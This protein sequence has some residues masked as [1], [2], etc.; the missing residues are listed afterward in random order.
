[1]KANN[2]SAFNVIGSQS[3]RALIF[4]MAA[5]GS[6]SSALAADATS[7]ATSQVIEVIA[8]SAITPLNFGKFIP[9]V[10]AGSVTI[11]ND[12]TRTVTAVTAVNSVGFS[13]AQFSVTGGANATYA[14]T[15][16]GVAVLTGV[17]G[18]AGPTM[19]LTK[20]S[21][22]AADTTSG[23]VSVGTLSAGGTQTIYVGGS[24]AIGAGHLPGVYEGALGVTV[25]YN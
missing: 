6:A 17:N 3:V 7:T 21:S 16:T 12:G 24:I 4:M 2:F 9:A 25:E 18:A 5:L 11:R 15:H 19:A 20:T 1:M 23:N 14:I 8:V 13:A 22:F 10:G